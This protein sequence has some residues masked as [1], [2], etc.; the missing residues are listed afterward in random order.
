MAECLVRI[1]EK[2]SATFREFAEQFHPGDVIAIKPDAWEW[3]DRELQNPHWII[4][5]VNFTQAEVESFLANELDELGVKN[6][7]FR[8]QRK[9]N[10]DDPALDF[11]LSQNFTT[12]VSLNN[13]QLRDLRM[14]VIH[15]GNA[16][17]AEATWTP[18]PRWQG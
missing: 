16:D 17:D 13:K 3:S 5:Q 4:I 1:R 11:L 2:G 12:V 8:R 14:A 9:I 15:K 10:P 7:K 18:K 6:K